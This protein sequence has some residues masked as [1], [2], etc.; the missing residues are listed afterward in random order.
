MRKK[1]VFEALLIISIA[2]FVAALIIVFTNVENLAGR[3]LLV[4]FILLALAVRGFPKLKGFSYTVW[5]FAAVTLS[6]LFPS[7]FIKVGSFEMKLLIV[8]LLQV[9]MFGMG[10]QMSLKDFSGV[11]KMPKGVIIGLLLQFTIMPL[12]GF[13]IAN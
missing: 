7:Y 13:S 10:S 4:G 9:I 6:M 3:L 2:F 5:I 12:V 8:P 11:I 1:K